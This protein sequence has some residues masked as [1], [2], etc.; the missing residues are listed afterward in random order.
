MEYRTASEREVRHLRHNRPLSDD[1]LRAVAPSIFAP[2]PHASRSD[3]YAYIPT[4]AVLDGLRREGFEVFHARQ[5]GCRDL[6]R[7]SY[8]KHLLRLRH[9]TQVAL[10]QEYPEIVL[11]N[12]HDGSS[13]Y[14]IY[15]GWFRLLCLNGLIVGETGPTVTVPHK[16]DI[17][18]QVIEGAYQ[19][20]GYAETIGNRRREMAAIPLSRPEQT[21]F[22]EAALTLR[23]PER[24][25]PIIPDALLEARRRN[26]L[27]P[28]LWTTFNRVQE[29]LMRGGQSGRSANNRRQR[30]RAIGGIDQSVALNR[31]LW[32]LAE[33]MADLKAA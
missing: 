32:T 25:P 27:N 6:T 22:A 11:V 31:A 4:V 28:D 33:R 24:T 5:S 12:S 18:D 26:D 8:T 23:W 30:V 2:E 16:G 29:N 1:D 17:K 21:A 10:D 13:S 14:R 7:H 19:V 3:K 9:P 20:L 15:P